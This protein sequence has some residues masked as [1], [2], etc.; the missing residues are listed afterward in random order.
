M[1]NKVIEEMR[2]QATNANLLDNWYFVNPINQRNIDSTYNWKIWTVGLDRWHLGNSRG[3]DGGVYFRNNSI[4]FTNEHSYIYQILPYG[5]NEIVGKQLTISLLSTNGQL[6]S[7]TGVLNWGETNDIRTDYCSLSYFGSNESNKYME[8]ACSNISTIAVKIEFGDHQ[9]LAHKVNGHWELNEIPNYTQELIKCQR[10]YRVHSF[11][12]VA[13]R[14]APYVF[15][16]L[17]YPQMYQRPHRLSVGRISKPDGVDLS[18]WTL[19]NYFATTD[20]L[21]WIKF[22]D[23]FTEKVAYVYD[24]VINAEI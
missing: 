24:V 3:D 13:D 16:G 2:Y 7:N 17:T 15:L 20:A 11:V 21:I 5:A 1:E 18:G 14:Q 12:P 6:F 10:F 23:S 8:F 9:T 19:E 22:S 4:E